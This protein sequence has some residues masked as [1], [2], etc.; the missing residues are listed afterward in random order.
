[1]RSPSLRRVA[2][3]LCLSVAPAAHAQPTLAH[4]SFAPSFSTQPVSNEDS[5]EDEAMQRLEEIRAEA[6]AVFENALPLKLEEALEIALS[7]SPTVAIRDAETR[8]AKTQANSTRSAYRPTIGIAAGIELNTGSG[9]VAGSSQL[10]G[11]QGRET[12]AS[13]NASISA[14]QLIY[15]F[16]SHAAR[17]RGAAASIRS[18]VAQEEQNI[19]DLRTE[20]MRQYLRA[21]AARERLAVAQSAQRAEYKRAEQIDAHVEVGLRPRIDRAT[22]RANVA[23]ATARII[24]AA[25][26]YDL[27]AYDLLSTLG[28]DEDR[29]LDIGWVQIQTDAL[30]ELNT[31]DLRALATEQRGEFRALASDLEAA[32]EGIRETNSEY[33]PTLNAVAG[34]SES[35]LIGGVGRWNAYIGARLSWDIYRGGRVQFQKR[36]QEAR[37]D[38]LALEERTLL[39]E[40]V[41]TIHRA[42]REIRGAK[43]LSDTR[44]IVVINAARQLELAEGRYETGL[45]NIV[46][47]SDAQLAYTE[48][49]LDEIDAALQLSLARVTLVSAVAGWQ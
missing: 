43:A 24:T 49:Q 14:N 33:L 47:L 27:S 45:G 4:F 36:E 29:T 41:Q 6:D 13:V 3:L 19:Q 15:D 48:A 20:V 37:R 28:I 30:E 35:L 9:Y 31:D 1:M 42:Q 26:E 12:A 25:T 38:R 23:H 34:A 18:A 21:G 11:S 10:G 39:I 32:E 40:L 5:N 16:G 46:E 7:Q 44:H 22:A 2:M 8:I 17:R